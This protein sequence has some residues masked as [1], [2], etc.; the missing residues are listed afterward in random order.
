MSKCYR[1]LSLDQAQMALLLPGGQS[2]VLLSVKSTQQNVNSSLN[3][4]EV[5]LKQLL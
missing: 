1:L 4:G 2:L 3:V 5:Y